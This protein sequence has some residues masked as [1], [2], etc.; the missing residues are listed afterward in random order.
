MNYSDKFGATSF[1]EISSPFS[2]GGF[3]YSIPGN[4]AAQQ[5]PS[6]F[7]KI[8]DAELLFSGNYKREGSD[9]VI[10]NDA[11]KIV[12]PD[13]FK[14][15]TRPTLTSRDGATLSGKI[16]EALTG[17]VNY[18]QASG[19]PEP[20]KEIGTVGKLT[21][22]ATA[23]R[24]GVAVELKIGDKVYKGDVVQ[25][26]SD[27]A[28]GIT[29]IDGTVFSLSSNA[30]MV[31]NEMVYDPNST[32]NSS[33][34]SLVQGTITFVAG[35]T[36]KNGNMRVDTPVATMG[37]RGTA[38]L[39]E[40]GADNGPTKFSVL[41]EPGNKVGT[42]NLYDKTTGSLIGTVSQAGQ[43]T[44]VT[45]GGIGQQATAVEIPKTILDLQNERSIIKQAFELFFP[46]FNDAN[47]QGTKGPGSSVNNLANILNGTQRANVGDVV[48]DA[49]FTPTGGGGSVT[50]TGTVVSTAPPL[51]ITNATDIQPP[52]ERGGKFN[53]ADQVGPKDS[54]VIPYIT[55]T[56]KLDSAEGPSSMPEGFPLRS[57]VTFDTQTGDVEYIPGDFRFLADGEQAIYTFSFQSQSG[58]FIFTK[59]LT[60][61]IDGLND[62]PIFTVANFAAPVTEPTT[63]DFN[64]TFSK[65]GT[66]T[67]NDA[68]FSDV[69]AGYTVQTLGVTTTGRTIAVPNTATLLSFLRLDGVVK[70]EGTTRGVITETFSAPASAFDYLAA[71]ETVNI[72]YQIR[73][74]DADGASRTA[75][76]TVTVTGTNDT[77]TI[78]GATTP[79][80]TSG[81]LTEDGVLTA[82]GVITFRD[83]D[84]SNSHTA[85]ASHLPSAGT[86]SSPLPGFDP[87]TSLLGSLVVTVNENTTDANNIGTVSWVYSLDNLVAQRLAEGQVVTQ[88]FTVTITD[89]SNATVTQPVTVTITGT[90]DVPEVVLSQ[91]TLGDNSVALTNAVGEI[92]EPIDADSGSASAQ[93]IVVFKDV[94]LVDTHAASFVEKSSNATADL[95]GFN[96]GLGTA[97]A[98]VSY[99]G[100]FALGTVNESAIDLIDLGAVTWTFTIDN[101]DPTLQS[102]AEGQTI[103]QV[104]TI[105]IT[106]SSNSHATVSKDVTVTITGTNDAPV[107]DAVVDQPLNEQTDAK[108]LTATIG[109]TFTDVDVIDI[110]HEATVTGV[111]IT[112]GVTD[113]LDPDLDLLALLAP[114]AVTKAAISQSG[115]FDLTFTAPPGAFDYL[116]VGEELVLTYTFTVDDGDTAGI[117]EVQT[118]R[119]TITGTNDLPLV[120]AENATA[121]EPTDG[122][123][124]EAT[125]SV[126]FTDVDLTDRPD[127]TASFASLVY[128]DANGVDVTLNLTQAQ[129]DALS[130]QLSIA[131][132]SGNLNNGSALW[133]YSVPSGAVDFLAADESLV[134]TYTL[135]VDDG[136]GTPVTTDVTVTITGTNDAPVITLN[137]G[138]PLTTSVPENTTEVTTVTAADVDNGATIAYSIV[139]GFGDGALFTID[140]TTGALSFIAAPNY[141]APVGGDNSYVVQVRAFDGLDEDIQTITVNVTDE[142]EGAAGNDIVSALE[143]TPAGLTDL[144]LNDQPG[145]TIVAVRDGPHGAAVLDSGNVTFLPETDFSGIAS[146]EYDVSDDDGVTIT[147]TA[148]VTVNVAP[149]AATPTFVTG[150]SASGNED[151]TISLGTI[152]A[153]VADTDGSET[154][155]LKLSDFPAGATFSVGSLAT[156]GPDAGKWII[157]DASGLASSP[158]TVTPPADFNGNFTLHVDAVVTDTATL[159]TGVATDTKT[160]GKDISV[161]VTP[162][163]DVP[164]LDL[165]ST[166]ASGTGFADSVD[167]GSDL[168]GIAAAPLLTDIDS[169]SFSSVTIVLTDGQAGDF[170]V[171]F[172]GSEPGGESGELENGVSWVISGVADDFYD[173]LTITF[174]GGLS[175]ADYQF[176]ITQVMFGSEGANGERHIEVTAN[177]GS[178]D[179]NVAVAT[180]E[181]QNAGGP[182]AQAQNDFL[183]ILGESNIGAVLTN[184]TLN[185]GEPGSFEV[186]EGRDINN[187]PAGPVD[188]VITLAGSFGTLLLLTEN[189]L[190]IE[191]G[192]FNITTPIDGGTYIYV[193]GVDANGNTLEHNPIDLLLPGDPDLVDI[194]HYTI[195]NDLGAESTAQITVTYDLN[196]LEMHVRTNSG[197]DTRSLWADMH[198][199]FITEIDGSHI[200]LEVR[201]D[202]LEN[203]AVTKVIVIDAVGL[204]T[205]PA[206]PVLPID[207]IALTGGTITG[208][209]VFDASGTVPLLDFTNLNM[210]ATI[211]QGRP[212]F[213]EAV[214]PDSSSSEAFVELFQ[215]RAFDV[216]G[217]TGA[218]NLYGGQFND[219]I[220][221]GGNLAVEQG[222]TVQAGAGNDLI[223][224]RDDNNWNIDGGE[225]IDTVRFVG[226]IHTGQGSGNSG[227]SDIEYIDLNTTHPDS[228]MIDGEGAAMINGGDPIHVLG[229][230][231]DTVNFINSDSYPDYYWHLATSDE[232]GFKLYEFTTGTGPGDEPAGSVYVQNDVHVNFAP[233]ID[234]DH[235]SV[236]ELN[237]GI[238]TVF[239]LEVFDDNNVP[240]E[241]TVT[242]RASEGSLTIEIGGEPTSLDPLNGGVSGT[243]AS[244]NTALAGGITYTPTN[245]NEQSPTSV[246]DMVT[247]T[248]ADS[249]GLRDELHFVFQQSGP[250]GAILVGTGGKDFIFSTDGNDELTGDPGFGQTGRDNFVFSAPELGNPGPVLD[251]ITDFQTGIDKIVLNN[252]DT[253]FFDQASFTSWIQSS[254]VSQGPDGA[255]L[256][257]HGDGPD[258]E[259]VLQGVLK[260]ALTMNDFI[261]HPGQ[262]A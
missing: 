135:S 88:T 46:N 23:I 5:T 55:G 248:V 128:K 221:T 130:V 73:V 66:L 164:V 236:E 37:I 18:A 224:I 116:A 166:D 103:T 124:V 195:E 163:N 80:S 228:V 191:L 214:G 113:G 86:I 30:R 205:N 9:L 249:H 185:D 155:V 160:F 77:P 61:T 94:D 255:H 184:Y 14:G 170:L 146:F 216:S 157:D 56:L 50:V 27:S 26:G 10:S 63:T 261:L 126:A 165:N 138:E 197:Y 39:V 6:G 100:T 104:Y 200:K 62:A 151:A 34:L 129:I 101:D 162:E 173:P 211:D 238:T 207:D 159:T 196:P 79:A 257:L 4:T 152:N 204:T 230:A 231:Q 262:V 122:N 136:Q 47:P 74:R 17:H 96:E 149:L 120:S 192:S 8:N 161:S 187:N 180:I 36:A 176:A 12:V 72:I 33:L 177:D 59:T 203:G 208:I 147:G 222:D 91:V 78:T 217:G 259:I 178:D 139:S 243:L 117:S 237:D 182:P 225:G 172:D 7:I 145:H 123:P 49:K 186:L 71:G 167:S 121:A 40:I 169:S 75:T 158:L 131:S 112:S 233:V 133:T 69:A 65:Q 118:V 168:T 19:Q 215:Y 28:V 98:G 70:A 107:I 35:Q 85:V 202:G 83:V 21:G 54:Q 201:E 20:P 153:A 226:E 190:N 250:G 148:T 97:L 111:E 90:N 247:V 106:D 213:Y 16:V 156:D 241:L 41:V 92:L 251:T 240:D 254:S 15:E 105:T 209:H 67:F 223:L 108:P 38:V 183:T 119:I 132:D 52:E 227:G 57:L 210:H 87:A 110:G 260:T 58:E 3:D 93:G 142:P 45:P 154:I 150:T 194:F 114:G 188:G 42:F 235:I 134:L 84:L 43:V 239:D 137:A 25:S 171:V 143:N 219:R 68:D 60:L 31:L 253:P 29:F 24:N 140:E 189:R 115:S 252:F 245:Y 127:V 232:A 141:E 242:A 89:S 244:I 76:L 32:S 109:V 174:T 48:L 198:D 179:S 193:L 234:G 218:D 256:H 44:L 175:A 99:I 181:V 246:N 51:V 64:G 53:I 82:S 229:N 1:Q 199:G 212:G 102:L 144:A 258:N 81:D 95:P 13:Y 125:G 11:R 22:T 2:K 206:N 220:D